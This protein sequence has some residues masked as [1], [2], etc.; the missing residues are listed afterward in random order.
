MDTFLLARFICTLAKHAVGV[1]GE[2]L[3]KLKGM[4]RRLKPTQSGMRPKNRRMLREFL[5]EKVLA[6]FLDLPQRLFERLLRKR[7]LSRSDATKLSVAFAVA[8]LSVAPV[9]PKNAA[10]IMLGHN[11]IQTGSAGTRR[12]HLH[13]PP[14]EVKNGVEL[15]FELTGVHP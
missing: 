11:I 6:R 2:H 12:V 14:E 4:A 8:L 3:E 9:R 1:S 13:F 7:V 5:D 15:E 10:S